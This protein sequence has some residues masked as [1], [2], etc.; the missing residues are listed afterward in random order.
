[1]TANQYEDQYG[2]LPDSSTDQAELRTS[3]VRGAAAAV[4]AAGPVIVDQG[5]AEDYGF[6]SHFMLDDDGQDD[7]YIEPPAVQ[8]LDLFF[9]S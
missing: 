4:A 9:T 1:M 8:V 7:Q 5:S 6:G 3:P 2:R